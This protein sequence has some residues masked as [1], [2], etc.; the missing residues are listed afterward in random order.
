MNK[1]DV[2]KEPA[3]KSLYCKCGCERVRGD[4][5]PMCCE[6]ENINILGSGI[7]LFFYFLK[8]IA[9]NVLIFV[10]VFD[11]YSMATNL[12]GVK[13]MSTSTTCAS[14]Y[15]IFR[16]NVSDGHKFNKDALGF[17]QSWLGLAA[18]AIWIILSRIIKYVGAI[19]NKEMDKNLTSASDFAI[20]IANLPYGEYNEEELVEYFQKL[21]EIEA[22][23]K[24]N[25]GTKQIQQ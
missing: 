2:I 15:C 14:S 9:I 19:K 1:K 24:K 6:L 22:L 12:M 16:D 7:L 23:E 10:L 5:Y 20:K 13:N 25:E 11:I 3:L 17:I 21:A 18:M 8:G 4:S